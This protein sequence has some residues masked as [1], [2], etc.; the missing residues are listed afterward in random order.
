MKCAK[1]NGVARNHEKALKAPDKVF[2]TELYGEPHSTMQL[3]I[4]PGYPSRTLGGGAA[5]RGDSESSRGAGAAR[6]G[7]WGASGRR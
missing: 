3:R 4:L 1:H 5:L 7:L 2:Y 6:L